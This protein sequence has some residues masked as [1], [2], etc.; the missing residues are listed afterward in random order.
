MNTIAKFVKVVGITFVAPSA[1]IVSSIGMASASTD[2]SPA[3]TT[4]G[5]T[6]TVDQG[7]WSS[8]GSEFSA[9]SAFRLTAS[10]KV[11]LEYF[12]KVKLTKKEKS[13]KGC[14]LVSSFKA[15]QKKGTKCFRLKRG[16]KFTNS[17]KARDGSIHW[18]EDYVGSPDSKSPDAKWM[19]FV[20]R[21]HHWVKAGDQ[22]G[23]GNCENWSKPYKKLGLTYKSVMLYKS[24]S[25]VAWVLNGQLSESGKLRA[26]AKAVCNTSGSESTVTADGS[27]SMAVSVVVWA[28]SALKAKLQ[29]AGSISASQRT[30]VSIDAAADARMKIEAQASAWC[31]NTTPPTPPPS[32]EKPTVSSTTINDTEEKG[33]SRNYKVTY[34]VPGSDKGTLVVSAKY[35]KFVP[36]GQPC[37]AS[38]VSRFTV[39]GNGQ[40][41]LTYCAPTEVPPGGQ[42]TVTNTLRDDTTGISAAPDTQS[43]NIP[44]LSTH[45]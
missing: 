16:A 6:V 22:H 28:K 39:S 38:A 26:Y 43:F 25:N 15:G 21:G 35:G 30:K 13:S 9:S 11:E 27:Y 33:F 8:A 20:V 7:T 32:T 44:A 34:N 40:L 18:Y 41:V 14:P 17:G 42:D 36:D 3:P 4:P 24:F 29:G 2:S 37:S 45:A 12:G 5:P 31:T 10:S 23:H 1:L 19:K